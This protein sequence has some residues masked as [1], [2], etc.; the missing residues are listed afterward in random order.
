MGKHDKKEADTPEPGSP[1]SGS[2]Q[3]T[4]E[5][6]GDST[7]PTAGAPPPRAHA[8]APGLLPPLRAEAPAQ[9]KLAWVPNH[10]LGADE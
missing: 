8:A 10:R 1:V 4:A 9:L 2:R 6:A 5:H 3:E 7:V